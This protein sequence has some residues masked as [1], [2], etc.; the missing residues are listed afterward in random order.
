MKKIFLFIIALLPLVALAQE[1]QTFEIKSKIGNLNTRARAYLI[2]QEGANRVIDSAQIING[3]FSFKGQIMNPTGALLVIDRFGFGLNTL[4]STSDNLSFYIDK[5]EFEI[6][7]KDSLTKARITGSKINDDNKRL[8]AQLQPLMEQAQKLKVEQD[9]ASPAQ[10]NTAEFQNAMQAKHK[11][12][13][14][15]EKA[16]FKIFILANPDSY[17]SLLALNSVGGPSPDPDELEA[18]YNSLSPRLKSTE[19]AKVFKHS[20]DALKNTAVGVTAPDF[21]Q[22]DVNGAPVSLSSFR[23]KY[24]L[25][26]FWASW[27]PPCRQESPNLVKAYNKYKDKNFTIL[28]VSL[29]KADGKSAWLSAIN[30]DGLRWTQVSDLKFW[31][32]AVAG[33]YYITSIPS[34]FLID[35]TGKII[36]KDLR[37]N[38]LEVKLEEVLGKL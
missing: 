38:D 13:Q 34:N 31:N 8:L 2:Y 23:G 10:R 26:D 11:E 6:N 5:G 14:S 28:G 21:T 15:A 1:P 4:D 37:G 30:N 33:L 19:T 12:L 32:N 7:S 9:T 17:L 3:S 35:P 20:L 18:L 25:V 36:A 22:A 16:T 29:D 24:V 27:C